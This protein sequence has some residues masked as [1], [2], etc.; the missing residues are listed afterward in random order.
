MLETLVRAAENFFS[1]QL[2]TSATITD[3]VDALRTR[4]AYVDIENG[5]EVHRV[6]I[7]CDDTLIDNIV[8][9]MLGEPA[10]DEATVT[11]MTLEMANLIVGSAKVLLQEAKGIPVTI[12][13]PHFVK[14]AP[15]DVECA[16][17]QTLLAESGTMIIGIKD[18]DE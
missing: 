14:H 13:T 1:H 8:M 2:G 9:C 7:G 17:Q 18:I 4:I 3:P 16:L 12:Q 6:Y 11:D 15:F 10:E 5:G